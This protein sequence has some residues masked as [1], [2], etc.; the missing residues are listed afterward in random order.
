MK[1]IGS[2]CS[3]VGPAV[4]MTFLLRRLLKFLLTRTEL[5]KLPYNGLGIRHTSFPCI[6][7]ATQVALLRTDELISVS[8]KSLHIGLSGWMQPHGLMHRGRNKYGGFEF[9]SGGS[10]NG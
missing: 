3:R 10:R 9:S 6:A 8:F 7:G 4:I 1:R 5:Q 2:Q